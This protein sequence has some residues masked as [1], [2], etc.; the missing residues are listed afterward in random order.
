[1][2]LG[3]GTQRAYLWKDGQDE[4]TWMA[5]KLIT[6]RE[7]PIQLLTEPDVEQLQ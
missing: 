6:Y 5:D 4:L 3:L 1:M 7:R 2:E